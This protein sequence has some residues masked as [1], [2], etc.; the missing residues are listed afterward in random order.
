[1]AEETTTIDA[2][3]GVDARN[4]P[5]ISLTGQQAVAPGLAP[6]TQSAFEKLAVQDE[7]LVTQQ[8]VEGEQAAVG[9]QAEPTDAVT[10]APGSAATI[11]SQQ[12]GNLTGVSGATGVVSEEAKVDEGI[13]GI[14]S[15]E[16]LSAG[17]VG[18]ATEAE[19]ATRA[20]EAGELITGATLAEEDIPS[21]EAATGEAGEKAT[22]KYQMEQLLQAFSGTDLPAFAGPAIRKANDIMEARGLSSSSIAGQ[23]VIRAA[24]EASIPIAVKDAEIQAQFGLASL[25]NQQQAAILNAQ[26]RAAIKGQELTNEQQSRV[27]NATRISEVNNMNLNHEQQVVLE[28]SRVMQDMSLANLNTA[29]QS[30]LQNA[31]VF[32]QMDTANLNSR[33]TAAVTNAKSFLGMDMA[34]LSNKQQADLLTYQSGVQKL[35]TDAAA[36]NAARQFNAKNTQQNEQF[37]ANLGA[38][39]ATNNANRQ[40]ATDQFNVDQANAIERSNADRSDLRDRFNSEMRLVIDQSNAAWRRSVNTANNAGD[41]RA[42]QLN[43]QALLGLSTTA[44]NNLWQSYRDEA[45]W[46]FSAAEN[47]S[48]RAHNLTVAAMQHET[49]KETYEQA[50][51]DAFAV[52]LGRFGFGIIGAGIKGIATNW[53][54]KKT[55]TTG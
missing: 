32:A 51:D 17:Q 8:G 3:S 24:M 43:A 16:A 7:E 40:A 6:G 28:N 29:Q 2:V 22:V 11:E 48:N 19:A 13:E 47:A 27:L 39:V 1:M 42:N 26:I 53:G 4:A 23:A 35:F 14:V 9:V 31:A 12:I 38:S 44:Q 54:N 55:P 20:V 18:A 15:G 45:S 50:Y 10:V 33:L 49:A 30:A 5:I 34:N 37:F 41:N 25:S 21:V 52:E 36:E 46:V